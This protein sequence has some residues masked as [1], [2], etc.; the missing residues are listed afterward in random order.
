MRHV[1]TV[2]ALMTL[3]MVF[4]A[5]AGV[6]S[7]AQELTNCLVEE[8]PCGNPAHLERL[9]RDCLRDPSKCGRHNDK[10]TVLSSID[11]APASG[12]IS[13]GPTPSAGKNRSAIPSEMGLPRGS[14]TPSMTGPATAGT[15]FDVL[16]YNLPLPKSARDLV[17]ALPV[18]AGA[19]EMRLGLRRPHV[20]GVDM[21]DRTP[22]PT[23]IVEALSPAERSR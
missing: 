2:W 23:E 11:R 13:S 12:L 9:I 19:V 10:A 22:L 6:P 8:T 3:S 5:A 21:R 14:S 18:D 7:F 15:P 1:T 16:A 20:V 4:V 17:D